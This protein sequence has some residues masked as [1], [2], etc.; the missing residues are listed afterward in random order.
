MKFQ[1]GWEAGPFSGIKGKFVFV[2]VSLVVRYD[3]VECDWD[4]P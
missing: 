1:H 4:T 3:S 2:G